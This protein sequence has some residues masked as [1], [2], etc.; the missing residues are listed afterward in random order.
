MKHGRLLIYSDAPERSATMQIRIT[1][2]L[3]ECGY[4]LIQAGDYRR[5][6]SEL[7]GLVEDQVDAVIVHRAVRKRCELYDRLLESAKAVG[8][9]VILD[10][11]DLLYEVSR[12]HPDYAVYQAKAL[13]A[14]KA[15]LDADLIVASTP[16]LARHLSE[17]HGKVVTIPNRL[18]APLWHEIAEQSLAD[19]RDQRGEGLTIGYIGTSSHQPDLETIEGALRTIL[20]RYQGRVRLL[21]VGMPLTERLRSLPGVGQILPPKSVYRDYRR[22]PEFA[23][24][25]PIDLAVAPLADS[26]FN[27]CKSDVKFQE[28]AALGIPGVYAALDPYAD[29]VRPGANGFLAA[30]DSQWVDGLSR[31]IESAEVRRQIRQAATQ[32]VLR[33]WDTPGAGLTWTEA[34]QQ[35]ASAVNGASPVN[36][37]GHRQHLAE[38]VGEALVYQ[39]E[40]ERQLKRTVEYQTTRLVGRLAR[41][42]AWWWGS[43]SL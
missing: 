1:A 36:G 15:V 41:R 24:R 6:L 14:L 10:T 18:P 26:P 34:L 35:A 38:I 12:R 9:P 23:S 22:F 11:D 37:D 19:T 25:L 42:F 40:V 30:D 16:T 43:K 4:Q 31:L 5:R 20:D 3:A 17:F 8:K 33:Q 13:Y 29:R 32:E 27:R 28:Y 21:T 2:P 7:R 39:A